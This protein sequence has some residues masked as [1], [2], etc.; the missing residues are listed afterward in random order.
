M[1]PPV[2]TQQRNL[3]STQLVRQLSKTTQHVDADI[4]PSMQTPDRSRPVA[5]P[6]VHVIYSHLILVFADYT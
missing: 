6:S 1:E 3:K 5:S 4:P 2:L